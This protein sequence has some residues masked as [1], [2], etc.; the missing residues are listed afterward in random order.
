MKKNPVLALPLINIDGQGYDASCPLCLTSDCVFFLRDKKRDYVKCNQC[1]L[2]HVPKSF[3][4]SCDEEKSIYDLHI[5][6]P[7]DL[8]Y[9][10]F[11]QRFINPLITQLAPAAKG[12]DFGSGPGPTLSVMLNE[13]GF[14]CANYDLYYDH[15]PSLLLDQYYDFVTSTEVVEHLANPHLEFSR[16]FSLLKPGACLA[17]MTKRWLSKESFKTWHYIQDPTHISFYNEA[18]F[19][20][21]A[22]VFNAS[23]SFPEKDVAIFIKN[24]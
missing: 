20:W 13:L 22:K 11:L 17:I 10:N 4:L 24:P 8:G 19:S 21:L 5:N 7:A 15:Q 6:N 2:I 23:L 18:T 9:R 3:Q 14:S 1:Q 12:L 16:L